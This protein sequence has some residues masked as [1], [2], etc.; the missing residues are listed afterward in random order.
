MTPTRDRSQSRTPRQRLSDLHAHGIGYCVTARTGRR[1]V[2]G[3]VVRCTSV[4]CIDAH[5]YTVKP[6]VELAVRQTPCTGER[7]A[8]H[9]RYAV[10]A[11]VA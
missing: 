1:S 5:R 3:V 7:F 11:V 10:E 8:L 4:G 6:G 2:V 9:V